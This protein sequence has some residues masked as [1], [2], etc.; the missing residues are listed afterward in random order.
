VVAVSE[1]EST[2][3]FAL[4]T[5]LL[6]RPRSCSRFIASRSKLFQARC[7]FESMFR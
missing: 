3:D 5:G 2:T 4:V 7:C 1:A 6:M